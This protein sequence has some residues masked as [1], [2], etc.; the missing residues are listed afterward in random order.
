MIILKKQ[1]LL[2]KKT[3]T[4]DSI[5]SSFPKNKTKNLKFSNKL[6]CE[7]GKKKKDYP[8][9]IALTLSVTPPPKTNDIYS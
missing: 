8:Y 2:G 6:Q 5:N 3:K 1:L 9:G 4:P 7:D